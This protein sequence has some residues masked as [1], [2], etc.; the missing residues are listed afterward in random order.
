MRSAH[1]HLLKAFSLTPSNMSKTPFLKTV[2]IKLVKKRRFFSLYAKKSLKKA[3]AS[4]VL[5]FISAL[6]VGLQAGQAFYIAL[7]IA[8]LTAIANFIREVFV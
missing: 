2:K 3:A 8:C 1:Q 4:A 7:A 5:G 6:I